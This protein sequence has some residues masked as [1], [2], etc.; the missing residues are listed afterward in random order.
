MKKADIKRLIIV[1]VSVIAALLVWRFLDSYPAVKLIISAVLFLAGMIVVLIH[2][3]K[4]WRC[5]H[6]KRL[7]PNKNWLLIEYC[8]HCCKKMYEWEG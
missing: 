8:P 5:P 3:L 6:C 2:T 7:L 4:H 1:I